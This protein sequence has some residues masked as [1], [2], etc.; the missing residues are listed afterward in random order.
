MATLA[1]PPV[2]RPVNRLAGLLP[3][4]GKQISRPARAQPDAKRLQP[5]PEEGG[6]GAVLA[7]LA[8]MAL[9]LVAVVLLW[10]VL[11]VALVVLIVGLSPF[12]AVGAGVRA[13][14]RFGRPLAG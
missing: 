13:I 5:C 14:L 8:V 1:T 11:F 12:V 3:P 6:P 7:S 9:A 2:V 4:P 10:P